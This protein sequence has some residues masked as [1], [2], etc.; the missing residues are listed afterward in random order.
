MTKK[1]RAQGILDFVLTF[2][3]ILGLFVGIVRIW[4]WFHANYARRQ[5][6]FQSGRL[7]A[8]NVTTYEGRSSPVEVGQNPG[9]PSGDCYKPMDLTT[10]WVFRGQTGGEL[11]GAFHGPEE[12]DAE[13][14]KEKCRQ[15]CEAQCGAD[16]ETCPCYVECMCKELSIGRL[17]SAYQQVID[18]YAQMIPG[19]RNSAQSLRDAADECDDPWELCAWVGG[20]HA[21]A[22]QLNSAAGEMEREA[23]SLYIE[24]LK[25]QAAKAKLE[26]CCDVT[27]YPDVPQQNLCISGSEN[28]SCPDLTA[29]YAQLWGEKKGALEGEIAGLQGLKDAVIAWIPQCDAKAESQETANFCAL[30][31]AFD[32][33]LPEEIYAVCISA[34]K[35]NV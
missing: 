24:S 12:V 7:F 27:I 5:V 25:L 32:P 16:M 10:E 14:V 3:A 21:T 6:A 22:D 34:C 4:V 9:C 30:Q 2:V 31:C 1:P 33:P 15:D 13:Q 20:Y 19:L 17:V 23:N 35:E 28:I 26:K 11:V 18:G 29:G 8:G